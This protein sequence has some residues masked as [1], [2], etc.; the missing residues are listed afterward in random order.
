MTET[1]AAII[2]ALGLVA[3][4]AIRLPYQRRARRIRIVA[5]ERTLSERLL[6]P[7]ATIGLAA[8]PAFYLA[9]GIPAFADYPFR[10]WMGWCGLVVQ[11]LFLALFH[12]SHRWLGR[13][14]SVTLEIRDGHR[15]VADGPYRYVRHPMYS[16]FWLWGIAQA[17]LL[18]NWVAGLSGLAGVGLLYFGRVGAEEAMMEKSFGDEY[19]AYAARTGRVFPRIF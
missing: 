9:T 8:I 11:I 12:A 3:W 6:L 19:R 2:W 10:P 16:S 4:F 5:A 13:N 1:L 15:L 7:A 18:P 17:L 14:W